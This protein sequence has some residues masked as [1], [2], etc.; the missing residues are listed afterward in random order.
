MKM[1]EDPL[2][3]SYDGTPY[4][5]QRFPTL[6]LRRMLGIGH[7]LGLTPENREEAENHVRVLD[8]GCASGRHICEQAQRYPGADFLGVD[9]SGAEVAQGQRQIQ[10][11]GLKNCTIVQEDL[12]TFES[13]EAVYDLILCHGVFSWVPDEA[14]EAILRQSERGLK[15]DGMTAIAY[16]TYPGWKQK[17][18]FRELLQFQLRK[19]QTPEARVKRSALLLRVLRSQFAAHDTSAQARSLL[20]LVE[21]M[22]R[23]PSNAFL[24]DELGA[25]HDPCYFAEFVDWASECGLDYLAEAELYTMSLDGLPAEAREP[26]RRLAPDFLET[27]QI[28]DFMVNRSGR[29]SLLCRTGSSAGRALL[30][31]RL[32]GVEYTTEFIRQSSDHAENAV[33]YATVHGREVGVGDPVQQ[34]FLDRLFEAMPGPLAHKDLCEGLSTSEGSGALC[35]MIRRGLAIPLGGGPELGESIRD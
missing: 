24:H 22:Q 32:D 15:P 25:V 18:A 19:E 27:Q 7:V 8:L 23:S 29:T 3:A 14:K 28:L 13:Q 9:F 35:E 10:E 33:K 26:L 1:E 31:D 20:A 17:E 12:R 2:Q 16:V 21:S 34:L 4:H 30:E 5:D 6:D 11:M